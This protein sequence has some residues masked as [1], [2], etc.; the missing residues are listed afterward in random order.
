MKSNENPEI[1]TC[2]DSMVTTI[3]LNENEYNFYLLPA[4]ANQGMM[5]P[6]HFHV[7]RDDIGRRDD[8][9][10]LSFKL[11]F[12]YYNWQGSIRVPAPV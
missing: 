4:S 11:C 2:I 8:L 3:P 10:L 9:K 7:I 6:T 12:M 5:I 1:G